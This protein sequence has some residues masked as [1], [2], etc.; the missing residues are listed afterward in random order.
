MSDVRT[1]PKNGQVPLVTCTGLVA[2]IKSSRSSLR[3]WSLVAGPIS[4][5]GP[6]P[7]PHP[8]ATPGGGSHGGARARPVRIRPLWQAWPRSPWVIRLW[9]STKSLLSFRRGRSCCRRPCYQGSRGQ[10]SFP[11]G[12]PAI[13]SADP[14]ADT[15][16]ISLDYWLSLCFD[17]EPRNQISQVR[18]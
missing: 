14:R 13:A 10:H 15:L 3:E 5:I 7:S 18:F 1:G 6:A 2:S 11:G 12:T 8:G 16:A 17:G 4:H 9:I